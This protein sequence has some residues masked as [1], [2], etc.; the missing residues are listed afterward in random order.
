MFRSFLCPLLLGL[1]LVTGPVHA[2]DFCLSPLV[3]LPPADAYGAPAPTG[4]V[5]DLATIST[6]TYAVDGGGVP[7]GDPSSLPEC[8]S[9]NGCSKGPICGRIV[10]APSD[11][12][13]QICLGGRRDIDGNGGGTCIPAPVRG[14]YQSQHGSYPAD[15]SLR[16]I[17][18]TGNLSTVPTGTSLPI[19][20]VAITDPSGRLST[21]RLAL[22]RLDP[23]IKNGFEITVTGSV[24]TASGQSTAIVE[25]PVLVWNKQAAIVIHWG[26]NADP[27]NPNTPS[28]TWSIGDSRYSRTL[29]QPAASG[30]SRIGNLG[31]TPIAGGTAEEAFDQVYFS[32]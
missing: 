6:Y 29:G 2:D 4:L 13:A 24:I 23:M 21:L 19:A 31:V 7:T 22:H 9:A 27:Q 32:N 5:G 14:Y 10:L 26:S 25:A 1:A 28:L 15:S 30:R 8:V 3:V 11:P 18:K 20:E 16:F 12:N 17:V